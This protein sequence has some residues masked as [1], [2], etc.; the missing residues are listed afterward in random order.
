MIAIRNR[1]VAASGFAAVFLRR[2]GRGSLHKENSQ[3]S[4]YLLKHG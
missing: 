2:G 1:I 3:Q 4:T